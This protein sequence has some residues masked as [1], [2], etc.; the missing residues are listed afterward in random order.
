MFDQKISFSAF[1]NSSATVRFHVVLG[2]SLFRFL[3][4]CHIQM[5]PAVIFSLLRRRFL[6]FWIVDAIFP[7]SHYFVRF[8][9]TEWKQIRISSETKPLTLKWIPNPFVSLLSVLWRLYLS[10]FNILSYKS[11]LKKEEKLWLHM[12]IYALHLPIHIKKK[13][14]RKMFF[15]CLLRFGLA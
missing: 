6:L 13:G 11:T 14:K 7:V 8:N 3:C 9:R 1:L 4:G 5:W 2:P 10:Y 15:S 12:E